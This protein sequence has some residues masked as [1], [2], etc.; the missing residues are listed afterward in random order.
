MVSEDGFESL[1]L[2]DAYMSDVLHT[3]GSLTIQENLRLAKDRKHAMNPRRSTSSGKGE[4][5]FFCFVSLNIVE[6]SEF[7]VYCS[8]EKSP[9]FNVLSYN[10]VCF[11]SSAVCCSAL[12]IIYDLFLPFGDSDG[13]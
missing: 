12:Q 4:F 5:I 1:F 3:Q 2:F 7:E 13:A 9:I 10:C 6:D 8:S 11:S